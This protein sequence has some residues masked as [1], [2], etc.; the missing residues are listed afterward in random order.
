M[1]TRLK[2]I[3]LAEI[4]RWSSFPAWVSRED[5]CA[6]GLRSKRPTSCDPVKHRKRILSSDEVHC[7]VSKGFGVVDGI[8]NRGV[9]KAIEVLQHVGSYLDDDFD[10]VTTA[11][12]AKPHKKSVALHR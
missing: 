1:T 6:C 3:P 9:Y 7:L 5:L 2:W 11:K 8:I 4:P 10:P 12:S